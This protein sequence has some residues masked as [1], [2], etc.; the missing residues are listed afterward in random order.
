MGG[1]L[2][3]KNNFKTFLEDLLL[4]DIFVMLNGRLSDITI[5]FWYHRFKPYHRQNH[6]TTL[7]LNHHSFCSDW[8]SMNPSYLNG[9][10]H[11]VAKRFRP[12]R[13]IIIKLVQWEHFPSLSEGILILRFVYCYIHYLWSKPDGPRF[14]VNLWMLILDRLFGSLYSFNQNAICRSPTHSSVLSKKQNI[15]WFYSIACITVWTEY[16]GTS[17]EK[18]PLINWKFHHIRFI[19]YIILH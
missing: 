14:M 15:G 10:L 4:G 7:F 12:T 11:E 1:G 9:P 17:N 18:F 2:N 5:W 6:I 16:D 8:I 13:E 3:S 19:L